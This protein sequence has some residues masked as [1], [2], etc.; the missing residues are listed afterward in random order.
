MSRPNTLIIN[1]DDFG[2][3]T[4]VNRAILERFQ[5]SLISSTSL[6][7]NM[8]GFEDAVSLAHSHSF[9]R[10][11]V[12]IH[13]NLTEGRPLTEGIRRSRTFCDPAG[14]FI[15]E[16]KQSLLYLNHKERKRVYTEM[17]AQLE[18]ILAAGIRPT[19]LDSHH[20]VHTEWAIASLA[21]RLAQAYRIPRIRLTRNTGRGIG[22]LK[23]IY[24]TL[25]NR[26]RLAQNE[27]SNTDYFGDI[28]DIKHLLAT[29][30]PSGKLIEIMVHPLFDEANQLIDLN[31]ANLQQELE[32]VL[33]SQTF[34]PIHL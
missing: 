16:R 17:T 6:M 12:G 15:Y 19:H 30:R 8:P 31:R 2:Y 7:A 32:M 33:E 11:R 24:K 3:S 21:C 9:L 28:V 20:H 23:T 26:W 5:R 4:V 1:A 13:V 25:L 27:L 10:N 18:R 34:T 22:L 14:Y 29:R